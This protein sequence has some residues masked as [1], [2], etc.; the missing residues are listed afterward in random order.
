MPRLFTEVDQR[1]PKNAVAG[2]AGGA[3]SFKSGG[4][5]PIE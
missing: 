2:D 4:R 5:D 3:F 1:K